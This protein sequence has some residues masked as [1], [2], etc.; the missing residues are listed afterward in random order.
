V[1][2]TI[3]VRRVGAGET[4]AFKRVA[5][6]VFDAPIDPAWL[7]AY[8]AAPNHF[9]VLAFE[10]D[11]VVGQCAAILHR[12]P[13][14]PVELYIDEVGTASTHRRLGVARLMLDAMFA[15]GRELGCTE[16]WLGTE[17]DNVAARGLYD[18]RSPAE[19]QEMMFYL[20]KV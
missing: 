4:R 5:P 9:L 18:G 13:D 8:L 1:S 20:F 16:A 19:A 7:A 15:W 12:H 6:E 14:K 17:L 11:V 3:T 2:G 10:N